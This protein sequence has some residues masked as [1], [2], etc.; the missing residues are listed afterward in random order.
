MR[1]RLTPEEIERC[2]AEIAAREPEELTVE[3]EASLAEA[4]EMDDGT[5]VSLDE[6]IAERQYSGRLLIRIP[7]E[8]HKELAEAAKTNG[9]SLNQYAIYRLSRT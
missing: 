4:E 8:L 3:E 7:K 6:H 9:V 5:Y 2:Y 1:K